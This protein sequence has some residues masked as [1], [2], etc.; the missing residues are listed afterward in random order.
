MDRVQ[1]ALRDQLNRQNKK[2]EIELRENVCLY[3]LCI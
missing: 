1:I 3:N 2:L